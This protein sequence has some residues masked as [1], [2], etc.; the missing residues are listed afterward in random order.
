MPEAV[1]CREFYPLH[2]QRYLRLAL[3][4][5]LKKDYPRSLCLEKL[6][7]PQLEV[8]MMDAITVIENKIPKEKEVVNYLIFI[9]F[10]EFD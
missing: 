1:R 7:D 3:S 2:R 9:A 4:C 5:G 10:G 8:T 6:P